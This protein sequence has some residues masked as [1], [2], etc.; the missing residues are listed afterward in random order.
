MIELVIH[1][2]FTEGEV[3]NDDGEEN[4]SERENVSLSAIVL[5]GLADFR[6][7]VALGTSESGQLIN[8]LISSEAKVSELQVHVVVEQDVL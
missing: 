4:Y 5:F 3:A 2:S 6:G 8:V 7:H 1:F